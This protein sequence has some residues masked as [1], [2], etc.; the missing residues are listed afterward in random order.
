M[1]PEGLRE[2][3][4]E[5]VQ[6]YAEL[7]QGSGDRLRQ[8][9]SL[10]SPEDRAAAVGFALLQ[11][12]ERLDPAEERRQLEYL[13]YLRELSFVCQTFAGSVD[14]RS[15]VDAAGTGPCF[16]PRFQFRHSGMVRVDPASDLIDG[17]ILAIEN[18]RKMLL[19]L[20]GGFTQL[21]Q[22][23]TSLEARLGGGEVS[24]K[25]ADEIKLREHQIL[26]ALTLFDALREVIDA[27]PKWSKEIAGAV[28]SG[29]A[30]LHDRYALHD[31]EEKK[32]KDDPFAMFFAREGKRA[33]VPLY[34]GNFLLTAILS[35]LVDS[36][37]RKRE[38][39]QDEELDDLE[40]S[41]FAS[42][43]IAYSDPVILGAV[44]G[45]VFYAGLAD[46]LESVTE[47][48]KD[49]DEELRQSNVVEIRRQNPMQRTEG[50][51]AL[52]NE[53]RKS[54]GPSMDMAEFARFG[55]SVELSFLRTFNPARPE[56]AIEK[57]EETAPS[58]RDKIYLDLYERIEARL[59]ESAKGNPLEKKTI[60]DFYEGLKEW[61]LELVN[62]KAGLEDA[63]HER[64]RGRL[65]RDRAEGNFAFSAAKGEWGGLDLERV[66]TEDVRYEDVIGASWQSVAEKLGPLLGYSELGFVYSAMSA[67]GRSNN[68]MLIVG[69]YGCGKNMFMRALLS[70]RRVIGIRMTTDRIDSMWHS[71]S[72][73][74]A[75]ALSEQAYAKSQEYGKPA[76]ICWDEFDSLFGRRGAG[77]ASVSSE[78]S[79]K[80]QKVLQSVLD[81]DTVYEGV[82]LVGLTN[83]P[84]RI[85]V[86]VYRRFRNV[87]VIQSLTPAE[88]YQLITKM[89]GS[90]PLQE[91]FE[92]GVDWDAFAASTEFASGDLL[93]KIYDEAYLHHFLP[94]CTSEALEAVNADAKE[95]V[96][97]GKVVRPGDRVRI[98]RKHT[99]VVITPAM[100][101]TASATVLGKLEIQQAMKQQAQFYQD[102]EPLI[103]EAFSGSL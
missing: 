42:N 63:S 36:I 51:S 37:P 82:S 48:L 40:V 10:L 71:V 14:W 100:F 31:E 73:N 76:L 41:G 98:F 61:I 33:N 80:M 96:H 57:P 97:G 39:G 3:M 50:Y 24:L 85:P 52:V 54:E 94:A 25:P 91:G 32:R 60:L 27:F 47:L 5:L 69:P 35:S 81:G 38:R 87:E 56:K 95:M 77:M 75:R 7:F 29:V 62:V 99:D 34:K 53:A 20:A 92:G 70:D 83:E 101:S 88:R 68:N 19:A 4:P 44:R 21:D 64:A 8:L 13:E 72:E 17:T 59:D 93:G 89:L 67:R 79:E 84:Q 66:P 46:F 16:S 26:D 45:R 103:A 86:P 78:I 1:E 12:H 6:A 9:L 43:M 90:L 58:D 55:L 11:Q 15:F 22:R 49:A 18:Q 30:T 102:I 23:L 28:K 65:R 74:N 2:R